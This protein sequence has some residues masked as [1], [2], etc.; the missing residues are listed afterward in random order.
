MTRN[1]E[2][3]KKKI[4]VSIPEE[5]HRSGIR[6]EKVEDGILKL[7]ISICGFTQEGGLQVQKGLALS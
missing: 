6:I 5:L 2:M 3:K 4:V 1:Q 7:T